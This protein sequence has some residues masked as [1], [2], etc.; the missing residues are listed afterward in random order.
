MTTSFYNFVLMNPSLSATLITPAA[1]AQLDPLVARERAAAA[2]MTDEEFWGWDKQYASPNHVAD[3]TLVD[4]TRQGQCGGGGCNPSFSN[5]QFWQAHVACSADVYG[6]VLFQYRRYVAAQIRLERLLANPPQ[7]WVGQLYFN[8]PQNADGCSTTAPTRPAGQMP[9]ST[10]ATEWT[11]WCLEVLRTVA[12]AHWASCV[13]WC[14]SD[15]SPTFYAYNPF[16]RNDPNFGG[17]NYGGIYNSPDV[18]GHTDLAA[19]RAAA[20]SEQGTVAVCLGQQPPTIDAASSPGAIDA[21]RYWPDVDRTSFGAYHPTG[22]FRPTA[23]RGTAPARWTWGSA[24]IAAMG[25]YSQLPLV[26]PKAIR[27]LSEI[28]LS[29]RPPADSAVFDAFR[30]TDGRYRLNEMENQPFGSTYWNG[31]LLQLS[32]C[33]ATR[34][35]N[36]SGPHQ[37]VFPENKA[38]FDPVLNPALVSSSSAGFFWIDDLAQPASGSARDVLLALMQQNT[39]VPHGL[40]SNETLINLRAQWQLHW[41]STGFRFLPSNLRQIWWCM[42]MAY[43]VVDSSFGIVVQQ[44]FANFL[45]GLNQIPPAFRSTNPNEASQAAQAAL[46]GNLDAI[47][48]GCSAAA[49][50]VGGVGAA[51][52][53]VPALSVVLEVVA[54]LIA[55]AGTL[56]QMAFSVGLARA[57]NPPVMP[58]IMTRVAGV[59][60]DMNDPCWLVPSNVAGG[61]GAA[62]VAPRAQ[63]V[64][65]AA[66]QGPS[67]EQWFAQVQAAI[68]SGDTPPPPTPATVNKGVAAAGG[69]MIGLAVIKL[70][71][72]GR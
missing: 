32:E 39:V 34:H 48:A 70:A 14:E 7:A 21:M 15:R 23:A 58:T 57:G 22:Y 55:I 1:R 16:G 3:P 36:E 33:L 8:D 62:A 28:S 25:A 38:D 71:L 26:A 47:M 52:S 29:G 50:V 43:D 46:Q 24:P 11:D 17:A 63:A 13:R 54:A 61:G 53:A 51:V 72:L 49:G 37:Y 68:A 20:P 60:N 66:A 65:T 40:V 4:L 6:R 10:K 67:P 2:Q 64:A 27:G 18:Y 12:V 44:A 41:S 42:G 30:T 31:S 56:A 69:A 5:S 45:T 59:E 9:I 35:G 19:F